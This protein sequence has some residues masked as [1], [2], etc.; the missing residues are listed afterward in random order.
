MTR[1]ISILLGLWV[2]WQVGYHVIDI[3]FFL[4]KDFHLSE[5]RATVLLVHNISCLA[6][7]IMLAP[8]SNLTRKNIWQ[9]SVSKTLFK[10]SVLFLV[11]WLKTLLKNSV[12]T[13]NMS[14][15][16][17]G[18]RKSPAH[19]QVETCDWRLAKGRLS[20]VISC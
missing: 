16:L 4:F 9:L 7:Q 18:S 1:F 19:S 5:M 13:K 14:C 3:F 17:N 6:V 12:L 10:N 15:C 2:Y 20:S 8:N 11:F